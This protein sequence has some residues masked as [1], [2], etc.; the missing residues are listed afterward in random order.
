MN[1][2][3]DEFLNSLGIEESNSVEALPSNNQT[4]TLTVPPEQPQTQNL[5]NDDFDDILE[6]FGFSR[7]QEAEA[8]EVVEEG[9]SQDSAPQQI[10]QA[11]NEFAENL[12]S[13]LRDLD[14]EE[15]AD[16]DNAIASGTITST[17]DLPEQTVETAQHVEAETGQEAVDNPFLLPENSPTLLIDDS[18]A[19]FSGAEWYEEIQ[20]KSIIFGGV[21][22]IGSN[23]IFQLARMH[24]ASIF[25][26]DDDNVETVNMAGQLFSRDD[27]GLTKVNAIAYMIQKYT[28]MQNIYALNERFTF[29]TEAGDIMMCGFDNMEARKTFF[30][31]WQAHVGSLPE[32]ERKRCLFIDGR[33]SLTVLQVFCIT[34]DDTYS[35][36]RYSNSYLFDDS[37]AEHTVCSMK[38]TTYL[39]CMIGSIMVN[40]FTN[41]VADSLDPVIPYDLPFFT[42]YDAQN[43]IFK[44]EN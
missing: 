37:E 35:I 15:D 18:T 39:A 20:R 16:W 3:L 34:G 29:S 17:E 23:A 42:E 30:F 36:E 40:L 26:Y 25:M 32:S 1:D 6:N 27:V 10:T 38:Q 9:N 33:L 31:K 44:T 22:G 28:N 14:A 11:A 5:S 41:W 19:R 12:A 4:E 21:G 7:T 43:M 13:R 24:P 8:E 2:N